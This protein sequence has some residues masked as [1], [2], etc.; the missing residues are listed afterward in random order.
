MKKIG[1]IGLGS[2]GFPMTRNLLKAGYD[3]YVLSRSR[4]PIE[5]AIKLGAKE[6][7]SPKSLMETVDIV[8]TCLPYPQTIIDVYE[9]NNGIIEGLSEG[10]MVIDHSTIN[11]DLSARINDQIKKKGA[12]FMESPIS[13]GPLKADAGTLT[14]I[15]GGEKQVYEEVFDILKVNGEYVVHVGPIGTASKIKVINNMLFGIHISAFLDAI[16]MGEKA[17]INLQVL[18]EIISRSTGSS[19][20][21]DWVTIKDNHKLCLNFDNG[22]FGKD[23]NLAQDLAKELEVSAELVKFTD[24][25]YGGG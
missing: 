22:L 25:I 21:M 1:F 6:L 19:K 9:G 20:A 16:E 23:M 8:F 11:H 15:C 12:V 18:Y 17:G 13:G 5:K 10:K 2:M 24:R 14:I 4:P 3:L 7:Q